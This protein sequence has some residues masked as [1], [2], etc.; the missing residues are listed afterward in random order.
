MIR[1]RVRVRELDQ[2]FINFA[3]VRL[4][5]GR[6]GDRPSTGNSDPKSSSAIA[7]RLLKAI[8]FVRIQIVLAV[9]ITDVFNAILLEILL[10]IF[11]FLII[12]RRR[13]CIG[14]P[15]HGVHAF[16]VDPGGAVAAGGATAAVGSRALDLG[17]VAFP[18]LLHLVAALHRGLGRI[19]RAS[20]SDIL[21]DFLPVIR[22]E[23]PAAEGIPLVPI[24]VD[25]R[26]G[27]V[28]RP[29]RRREAARGSGA[30]RRDGDVGERD[31]R[32][33]CALFLIRSGRRRGHGG[34]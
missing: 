8:P 24:S 27:L 13:G 29:A 7:H 20:N 22:P 33:G 28:V 18:K 19:D 21:R 9:Y 3:A 32:R 16:E 23:I 14:A 2:H 4:G 11:K 26:Y 10:L 5:H 25:E 31:L 34:G 1:V 17:A 6:S 12:L 15:F 30:V